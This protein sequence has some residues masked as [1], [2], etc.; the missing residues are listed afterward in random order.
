M[1]ASTIV[2]VRPLSFCSNPE[3]S[4]SNSFQ[5]TSSVESQSE[6]VARAQL[7]FDR[8]QNV[9]TDHGIKILKFEE[10]A[11]QNTPD[12]LFPNNW[13]CKLPDGR[14]FLFP[15]F[16]PNRRRE[17]RQDVIDALEAKEVIDLRS[18]GER[19]LYLEGTGSLIF[20]HD[21]KIAYACLAPRT[22]PELLTVFSEQSGYRIVSFESVDKN[23]Q[24][25]YHTNVMMALGKKNV[26]INIE[27]IRNPSELALLTKTFAETG[28][29]I[30]DITHEQMENFD[31]NMLLLQNQNGVKFWICST[32]AHDSLKTEQREQLSQEGKILHA[33]LNTIE[34]Y[35]GGGAR[36][37]MGEVF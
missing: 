21:F 3:T 25:I 34:T 37:L 2:M 1:N 22:S 14:V 11:G 13:F 9:L 6:I 23:G 30:V 15:M 12:A 8:F 28:K 18:Y 19:G 7:E 26:I 5:N 36:C 35:G 33:S 24:Q 27:S 31:G 16:A 29:A 10:L 17:F 4:G 20:D 32:R